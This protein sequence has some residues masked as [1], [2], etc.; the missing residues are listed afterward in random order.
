MLSESNAYVVL[1]SFNWLKVRDGPQYLVGSKV[2][3]LYHYGRKCYC[4]SELQSMGGD[5]Y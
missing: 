2:Q 3:T 5:C 4:F 1:L